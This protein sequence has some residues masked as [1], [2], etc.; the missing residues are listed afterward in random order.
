M[1]TEKDKYLL[2][3][4]A[5][6]IGDRLHVLTA[7]LDY[8]EKT[9]RKLIVDW[10]DGVFAKPGVDVF[11]K[12]FVCKHPLYHKQKTDI[13]GLANASWY[14]SIFSTFVFEDIY[15]HYLPVHPGLISKFP[16]RLVPNGRF[17]KIYGYWQYNKTPKRND[18]SIL[19]HLNDKNDIL[20]GRYLPEKLHHDVV[21][22]AD[23]AHISKKDIFIKFIDISDFLKNKIEKLA[24][25]FQ[26]GEKSVGVHIRATDK[27]P[28][29]EIATL[30]KYLKDKFGDEF[31]YF[32]AT[33]NK[34]FEEVFRSNFSKVLCCEKFLP[35]VN[36][37]G[38]HHYAQQ[39]KNW[40][41]AEL[42]LEQSIVDMW[43]LSKCEYLY[44]MG[45]SS[46]SIVS[47]YMHNNAAKQLDWNSL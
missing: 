37:G 32:I 5:A 47:A 8:C 9:E 17:C 7:A 28:L 26:L 43:L 15:N 46:F 13:V 19:L 40:D 42:V 35:K 22:Y 25:E 20:Q 11:E 16:K 44:Y 39:T 18:L 2:L 10:A 27:K 12:Y 30:L 4:G 3:K 29:N 23:M 6:G 24:V 38:V 1:K 34:K 45:N 14:P 41:N 33:D 31:L 36:I 21:V